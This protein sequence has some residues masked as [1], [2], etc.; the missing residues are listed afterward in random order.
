MKLLHAMLNCFC[1]VVFGYFFLLNV[2]EVMFSFIDFL[3]VIVEMHSFFPDLV[4]LSVLKEQIFRIK[5]VHSV[6][7]LDQHRQFITLNKFTLI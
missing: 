1:F 2:L 3:I 5:I 6:Y 4:V 7:C